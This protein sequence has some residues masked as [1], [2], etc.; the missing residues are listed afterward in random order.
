[1]C[2]DFDVTGHVTG[3]R[4]TL[5]TRELCVTQTSLYIRTFV[6]GFILLPLVLRRT[7][8]TVIVQNNYIT[9]IQLYS[10]KTYTI[11]FIFMQ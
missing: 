10:C 1:M 5:V 6:Y 7:F 8:Y 9:N 2:E 11:Q 4:S 3:G